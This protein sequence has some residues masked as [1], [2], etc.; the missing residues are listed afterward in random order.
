MALFSR[1]SQGDL[2]T[3]ALG[4]VIA[5]V[6]GGLVSGML[7]VGGGIVVVPILYQVLAGLGVD[8]SVRMQVATGSVLAAMLPC[9]VQAAMAANGKGALDWPL[10]R[11]WWLPL[12]IGA[13]AAGML[14]AWLRGRT[15]TLLFAVLAF[16]LAALFAVWSERKRLRP[17]PPAGIA[18]VAAAFAIGGISTLMGLGGGTIGVPALT[19]SG[20]AFER[21]LESKAA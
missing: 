4:L 20:F 10:L 8:S 16:P 11:R 6:A 18:G 13:L 1:V 17:Q 3:L 19:S 5:G 9:A 2:G 7:G 14:A 15:L 21:A 12:L